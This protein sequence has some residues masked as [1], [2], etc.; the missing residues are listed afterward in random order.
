M[1]P[2]IFNYLTS[3]ITTDV[4]FYTITT[5]STSIMSIKNISKFIADHKDSDYKLFHNQLEKTDM[6][7]KFNMLL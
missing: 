1:E 5:I 6:M 3:Y 7:H 4:V 2:I